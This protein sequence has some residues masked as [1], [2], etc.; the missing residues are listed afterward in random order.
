M[1]QIQAK[2]NITLVK[3]VNDINIKLNKNFI[4]IL[5]FYIYVLMAFMI[6][7]I[8]PSQYAY[9]ALFYVGVILAAV[10]FAALAQNSKTKVFFN[11]FYS[12]SFIVLFFVLGF[13]KFSG[14]DDITYMRIFGYVSQYGWVSRFIESKIE[15]GYLILN[16]IV[17]SF[18]DNYLYMQLITSFIPLALFYH[19]LKKYKNMINLPMAIFLLSTMIY[20]QMVS[21]ALVRMFISVSIVFNAFYY[22]PQ[23]NVKK[24]V[25]L[26]LI[27]STFHYSA[28][29]MLI[30]VYFMLNNKKYSKKSKRF[31]LIGFLVTPFVFIILSKFVVPFMGSRY[32]NYGTIGDLSL[33]FS[34]FDTIPILILLLLY[35]KKFNG[36]KRNYY[37]LFISIF[38]LSS[39][40]SF[41]SSLVSFGRLIFYANAAIFVAAPMVSKTLEENY[42]KIIFYCIIIVYG[43]LYVYKTQFVLEAHIFNLFP[44]QNIFFQI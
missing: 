3:K 21:T 22:V 18:T 30:L 37:D 8:L 19:A 17:S 28:L 31:I 11:I 41:Y 7:L 10:F 32:G 14:V 9:T 26:I 6:C 40:M 2:N 39:I 42:R 36:E 35:I 33:K 44:Y 16:S 15:P 20:F 43:F 12:I 38:A 13:R 5:I 24:Y 4:D 29:F 23:K 34:N 25:F 27:A 1:A